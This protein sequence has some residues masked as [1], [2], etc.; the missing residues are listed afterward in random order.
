[1]NRASRASR[2]GLTV[3]L[4]RILW[5]WER[6][7]DVEL[8]ARMNTTLSHTR[9]NVSCCTIF[10]RSADK[11]P[12]PTKRPFFPR[13]DHP[14]FSTKPF[15][16]VVLVS[17]MPS[18][19][20]ITTTAEI[21]IILGTLGIAYHSGYAHAHQLICLTRHIPVIPSPKFRLPAAKARFLI[22]VRT[23]HKKEMIFRSG[24]STLTGVLAW[25]M[26]KP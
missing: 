18:S 21:L 4:Q 9:T 22:N 1:M 17:S 10:P 14:V 15:G 19:T 12:S 26:V 13:L 2:L 24:P 6:N 25:L 16:I 23:A 20:P 3:G 8:D 7:N 11:L 5:Q